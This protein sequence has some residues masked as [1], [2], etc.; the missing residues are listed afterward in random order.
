ME[1]LLDSIYAGYLNKLEACLVR[2][3]SETPHADALM[4]MS[5]LEGTTLFV[6]E[7]CRFAS[8]ALAVREAVFAFVEARYGDHNKNPN[9][10]DRARR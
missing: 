6:G 3:G 5:L 4:L 8:N 10:I 1:Q 7:D 9:K 2:A